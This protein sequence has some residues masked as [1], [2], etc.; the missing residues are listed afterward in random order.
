MTTLIVGATGATGC[1]LVEQLLKKGE[2]VKVVVRN[3]V[4]LPDTIST[5]RLLIP[6]HKDNEDAADYLCTTTSQNA[7]TIEWVIVRPDGLIN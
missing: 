2:C 7:R 4:D 1:L 6:P 3:M 5:L